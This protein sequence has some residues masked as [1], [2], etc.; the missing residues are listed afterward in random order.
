MSFFILERKDNLN[1]L[2]SYIHIYDTKA[3]YLLKN[4]YRKN[5]LRIVKKSILGTN[6]SYWYSKHGAF[7]STILNFIIIN[8][9]FV[10]FPQ[11]LFHSVN[12]EQII[13]DMQHQQE[14]KKSHKNISFFSKKSNDFIFRLCISN[15][16]DIIILA[17]I[18][19]NYKYKQKKINK[20]MEKY[21][22]CAISPENN[23]IKNK[24]NCIISNDGKYRNKSYK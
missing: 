10:I 23:L 9:C 24:F 11:L 13:D 5:I 7:I 2:D 17:V 18:T 20:Y 12:I 19:I 6:F 14:A 4:K 16:I 15:M 8:T 1:K 22:Q 21:T 3:L